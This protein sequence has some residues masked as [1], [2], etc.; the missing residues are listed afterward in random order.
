MSRISLSSQRIV[1]YHGEVLPLWLISDENL[2][3]ADIKWEVSGNSVSLRT[4]ENEREH[5]FNDGVLLRFDNEGEAIVT[6]KVAE[7]IFTCEVSVARKIKAP[8]GKLNYY[9]GDLHTHTTRMHVHDD[10]VNRTEGFQCDMVRFIKN[11]NLLDFGVL[12]DH[13]AVMNTYEFFRALKTVEQEKPMGPI[14]FPGSESENMYSEYDRLGK[15]I[16]HAG[17]MV[18]VNAD[19]HVCTDDWD[20]FL[21]AFK[22]STHPIGIFAHPA[23]DSWDYDFEKNA[24]R[25]E[26]K[27]IVRFVEIG[28]GLDVKNNLLHE[29]AYSRALDAGFLVSTSSGSDGHGIWG[30]KICPGKTVIMAPE[31]SKE[32]FADALLNLRAYASESANVKVALS[33]NGNAAPAKLELTDS[34]KFRLDL[35]YFEEDESTKIVKCQVIS[36]GGLPVYENADFSGDAL[37][38]EIKSETARYFYLRLVDKEG[39]RTFSPP[40]FCGRPYSKYEEPRV[41]PLTSDSFTATDEVTKA[42][43]DALIHFDGETAW[44]NGKTVASIVIDMQKTETVSALGIYYSAVPRRE[45]L[46]PSSN[47]MHHAGYP[48]KYRISTSLDGKEFSEVKS[49]MLRGSCIEE[50]VLFEEHKARFVRFESLT[51]VGMQY[52][53]KS[54]KDSPIKIGGITLYK[55]E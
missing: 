53:R 39:R 15:K 51:T 32:A 11:E 12:S 3:S 52:E 25:S 31:K 37:E 44:T 42:D 33:V 46:N 1:G 26:L 5:P 47:C 18:V 38:F 19:Y 20:I 23:L 6:A 48:R 2:E 54:Y 8:V 41:T 36:D 28:N 16:R 55:P 17:E 29:Y 50:L 40:V 30:Y 49:G 9:R 14:L 7:D 35:S 24:K 43:A 21:D 34:Y 13:S 4:F 27:R 45:K 22:H 10:F